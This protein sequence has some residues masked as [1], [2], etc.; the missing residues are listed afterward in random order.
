MSAYQDGVFS[1]PGLLIV[2]RSTLAEE[3]DSQVIR[4]WIDPPGSS[5]RTTRPLTN[6][7]N[8]PLR[9]SSTYHSEI[10]HSSGQSCLPAMETDQALEVDAG[11]AA[12]TSSS[13]S[14]PPSCTARRKD[15]SASMS[16]V[17]KESQETLND[18]NT[19]LLARLHDIGDAGSPS[20]SE[21][22]D[23]RPAPTWS[24]ERD[25]EGV[26]WWK[27]PSVSAEN[28]IVVGHSAN[29]TRI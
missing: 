2:P 11:I 19:P 7:S 20:E 5:L 15:N 12:E 1:V 22:A 6:Q 3:L 17:A 25:F 4:S 13:S 18:E 26:P 14:R 28:L 23:D 21:E 29:I 10:K 8:A 16:P 9:P 27:K 24:G